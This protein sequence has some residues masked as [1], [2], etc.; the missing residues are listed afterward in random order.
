MR[1]NTLLFPFHFRQSAWRGE[2]G[3]KC[4]QVTKSK[5]TIS[6]PLSPLITALHVNLFVQAEK[7]G[8]V[9]AK[10]PKNQGLSLT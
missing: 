1:L 9:H 10:K 8:E 7:I 2:L 4:R 5:A 3:E 6:S